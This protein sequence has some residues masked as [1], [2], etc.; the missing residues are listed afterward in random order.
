MTQCGR[1]RDELLAT[2]LTHIEFRFS[3]AL[4]SYCDHPFIKQFEL[5]FGSFFV[6]AGPLGPA[7]LIAFT[8][9]SMP[10]CLINQSTVDSNS[11]PNGD[12]KPSINSVVASKAGR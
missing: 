3:E 4:K 12:S 1:K 8:S 6:V 5:A 7:L 11:I 2:G 10:S 9:G